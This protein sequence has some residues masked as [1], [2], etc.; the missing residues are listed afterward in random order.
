MKRL[1][2]VLVVMLHVAG[3][4][5]LST[6][7]YS[8]GTFE[9]DSVQNGDQVVL[10]TTGGE[11]RFQVPSVTPEQVC[12]KDECVRAVEIESV[13]RQKF[14]A[15]KTAAFVAGIALIVAVSMTFHP[16]HFQPGT[17]FFLCGPH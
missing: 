9:K 5:T 12:G 13:E 15:L 17:C 8:R 16:M 4:T 11:R 6:V 2:S 10:R 14:S 3:C 7:P 1:I